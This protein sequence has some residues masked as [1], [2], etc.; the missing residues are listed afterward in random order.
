MAE[1]GAR[2]GED[3]F[4]FGDAVADV[5]FEPDLDHLNFRKLPAGTRFARCEAGGVFPLQVTDEAGRDVTASYFEIAGNELRTRLPV[6][7]SMLTVNTTAVRQDC[8]CY[9]MEQISLDTAGD[10]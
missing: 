6:M 3:A 9:L 8:L 10:R 5:R 2:L 7:P 1:L 4:G